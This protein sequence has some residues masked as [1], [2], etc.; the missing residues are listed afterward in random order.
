M[1]GA[2]VCS[3]QMAADAGAKA[4]EHGGNAIDATVAVAMAL[5]VL[6]PANCG[7]GGYGGFM[8]VQKRPKTFP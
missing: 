6:D 7:V 8:V 3:H 1:R 5:T 2:V 4:M